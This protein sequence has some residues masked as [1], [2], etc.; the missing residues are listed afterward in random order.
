MSESVFCM[1]SG[2]FVGFGFGCAVGWM[3]GDSHG[4][5]R[6]AIAVADLWN[7]ATEC[8]KAEAP[9]KPEVKE[10]P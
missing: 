1:V 7:R 8:V 9:E 6:G 2:I 5:R 4:F 3:V 10:K